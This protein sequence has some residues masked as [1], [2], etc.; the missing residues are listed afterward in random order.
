M[1]DMNRLIRE[2]AGRAPVPEP[3]AS[4]R[5]PGS[6]GVG[7]GGPG[8]AGHAR[9]HADNREVNERLRAGAALARSLTIAGGVDVD[10]VSLDPLRRR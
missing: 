6:A 3:V 8:Y 7:R 5:A 1:T 9:R 2:R 10:S 4:A